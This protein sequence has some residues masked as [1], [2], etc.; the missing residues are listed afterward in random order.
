MVPC[1]AE[2][3]IQ[4]TSVVRRIV[5]DA[6]ANP[7]ADLECEVLAPEELRATGIG[8]RQRVTWIRAPLASFTTAFEF[9]THALRVWL[10][11]AGVAE[12][13]EPIVGIA[14]CEPLSVGELRGALA[15]RN[16]DLCGSFA[17]AYRMLD[18]DVVESSVIE[19][20]AELRAYFWEDLDWL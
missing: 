10:L 4:P 16:V 17:N 9:W 11:R 13:F 1:P 15:S 20:D 8:T 18:Q 12:R 5:E 14:L 19:T 2:M 6:R 3:S 7:R